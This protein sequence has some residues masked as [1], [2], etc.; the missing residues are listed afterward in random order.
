VEGNGQEELL[1]VVSGEIFPS[2]GDVLL[3]SVQVCGQRITKIGPLG[4]RKIGIGHIPADRQK[5]G[6]FVNM[7][8][9]VNAAVGWQWKDEFQHHGIIDYKAM[10]EKA[11]SIIQQFDVRT[12]SVDVPANALS[13]GN[14]Q[15][16]IVGREISFDP[17]VLIAAY[18]TRGVDVG[19][20][21]FIYRQII[22]EKVRGKAILLVSADLEEILALSDRIGVI[23]RGKI[24]KEFSREEATPEQIGLYMLGVKEE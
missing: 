1:Q 14:Q 19:A 4:R 24:I 2:S 12:P 17:S 6:L 5:Q 18:P 10:R 11:A 9:Y 13:G 7:P 16:F 3:C 21:E 8:L 23:Y 20:T 22:D 15:K